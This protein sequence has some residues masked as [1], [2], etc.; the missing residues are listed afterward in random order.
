EDSDSVCASGSEL[1]EGEVAEAAMA[2]AEE[3]VEVAA[4]LAKAF[5]GAELAGDD[6]AAA[7]D[8][9]DDDGGFGPHIGDVA[10][11]ALSVM[12]AAATRDAGGK[13]GLLAPSQLPAVAEPGQDGAPS[14]GPVRP[15]VHRGRSMTENTA[16]LR[17]LIA[18]ALAAAASPLLG[19][20]NALA[21][22]QMG[23]GDLLQLPGAKT[24]LPKAAAAARDAR[25]ISQGQTAEVP[26][27]SFGR[28]GGGGSRGPLEIR[29]GAVPTNGMPVSGRA[30]GGRRSHA[31]DSGAV[32]TAAATAAATAMQNKVGLASARKSVAGEASDGAA[33]LTSPRQQPGRAL[34]TSGAVTLP[35]VNPGPVSSL[36]GDVVLES[37]EIFAAIRRH[38]QPS[39]PVGTGTGNGGGGGVPYGAHSPISSPTGISAAA[40]AARA[41]QPW[42]SPRRI[43]HPPGAHTIASSL[44]DPRVSAT[45]A[46]SPREPTWLL[47]PINRSCTGPAVLGGGGAAAALGTANVVARVTSDPNLQRPIHLQHGGGVHMAGGPGAMAAAAAAA[48]VGRA[49]ASAVGSSL[50]SSLQPYGGHG[51]L[52]NG[53][54]GPPVVVSPTGFMINNLSASAAAQR[55]RG[56]LSGSP[57]ETA[58]HPQPHYQLQ[59]VTAAAAATGAG[60]AGGGGRGVPGR[61]GL[62]GPPSSGNARGGS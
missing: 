30:V 43:R 9:E 19:R 20:K 48:A 52:H 39:V 10:F 33:S 46:C 3:V 60:G 7:S 13:V 17:Y 47:P 1:D 49:R 32:P 23:F 40:A 53:D 18:G 59:A 56:S 5:L 6:S 28:G 54:L 57:S 62:A 16:E 31:S 50:D 2:E 38:S 4:E 61:Q 21:V 51:G 26:L 41:T 55:T 25:S 37:S 45:Q 42:A 35:A 12:E 14:S 27:A 22:A 15:R 24:L 58:T 8:V 44:P 29:A 36:P 34:Q 11:E